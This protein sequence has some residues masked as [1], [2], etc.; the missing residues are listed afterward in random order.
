MIKKITEFAENA[1]NQ[2][3]TPITGEYYKNLSIT[4][5]DIESGAQF[6]VTA[7]S[8]DFNVTE[9]LL[10]KFAKLIQQSG[11]LG[12]SNTTDYLVGAVVVA[13]DG[14]IYQ[15]LQDS[16][17]SDPASQPSADWILLS[18]NLNQQLLKKDLSNG[19]TTGSGTTIATDTS[20]TLTNPSVGTQQPSD[21]SNLAASTA[22]VQ[23]A[24][25]NAGNNSIWNLY[26]L[27]ILSGTKDYDVLIDASNP[28]W[29]I[30]T[31]WQ[32]GQK[33]PVTTG[34]WRFLGEVAPPGNEGERAALMQLV[35]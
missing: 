28:A 11:I 30:E 5:G 20:P 15:A 6:N 16:T 3:P 33:D 32:L 25:S 12:W 29:S 10:S 2:P 23:N 31:T 35:G 18:D 8:A 9:N 19:Q 1:V 4:P 7:S 27:K 34:V 24:Y 14:S 26:A 21:S 22:F 17:G 13:S